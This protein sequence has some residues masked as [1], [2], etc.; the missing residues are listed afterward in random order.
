MQQICTDYMT[1]YAH[2]EDPAMAGS[3]LELRYEDLG[4][5]WQTEQLRVFTGLAGIAPS[6]V[7]VKE[8]LREPDPSAR[9]PFYSSKYHRPIDTT[10]R[11][12]PLAGP[13]RDIAN[14]ICAPLMA[15]YGYLPGGKAEAW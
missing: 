12:D 6:Q 14:E 7:W 1:S 13:F 9:D 10:P 2:L 15:R 4:A 11:L 5:D 3:V 8:G